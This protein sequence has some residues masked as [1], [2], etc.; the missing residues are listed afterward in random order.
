MKTFPGIQPQ[1]GFAVLFIRTMTLKATVGK[2]WQY[3][4]TEGNR[5]GLSCQRILSAGGNS[6]SENP[7]YSDQPRKR[8][9]C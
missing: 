4:A 6:E 9:L 2:N 3:F 7:H 1:I 5:T 8:G